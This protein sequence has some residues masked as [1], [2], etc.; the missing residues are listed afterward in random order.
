MKNG[1][2]A[3]FLLYP[4]LI[5][6]GMQKQSSLMDVVGA[7][8]TFKDAKISDIRAINDLKRASMAH[9]GYDDEFL[10]KF[11]EI[12]GLTEDY[13]NRSITQLLYA[14]NQLVGFYSLIFHQDTTLELDNLYVHPD[15][16][17][18]GFGNTLWFACCKKAK[19]LGKNEFILWSEPNAENFYLKKGCQ[20]TGERK[21]LIIPNRYPSVLK[22]KIKENFNQLES[23]L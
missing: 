3:L 15:Y 9:W 7:E 22:F 11:M 8:K 17:G 10:N 21:S 2:F 16:I 20:K 12:T 23:K 18:N 6:M 14:H 4:T 13:L 5:L 19:D 1:T